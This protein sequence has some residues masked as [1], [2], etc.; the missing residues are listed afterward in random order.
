MSSRST[1]CPPPRVSHRRIPLA[2]C[3]SMRKGPALARTTSSPLPRWEVPQQSVH[4]GGKTRL[5]AR[6]RPLPLSCVGARCSEAGLEGISPSR[7]PYG[8]CP[9]PSEVSEMDIT[10]G[11]APSGSAGKV[12]SQ[13]NPMLA[14]GDGEA[15]ST[16]MSVECSMRAYMRDFRRWVETRLFSYRKY[17][18]FSCKYYVW[19]INIPVCPSHE[20]GPSDARPTVV[21]PS[22]VASC[23]RRDSSRLHADRTA[24]RH[25]HHRRPD[26]PAPAGGA[27]GARGRPP[28]PVRQQPQAARPGHSQLHGRIWSSSRPRSVASRPG[29]ASRTTG[30]AGWCRSCRMMEQTDLFNAYNFAADRAAY[31]DQLDGDGH[32]DRE[33][34]LPE[35]QRPD[36]PDGSGRL[37]QPGTQQARGAQLWDIAGTGDWTLSPGRSGRT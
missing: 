3:A 21:P 12:V 26:R 4:S 9:E 29:S 28:R 10:P 37:E 24:G 5:S 19:L 32:A 33:L 1:S 13:S 31:S 6:E 23:A 27:G 16:R 30:R 17:R 35:L 22:K 36:A 15:A 11:G 34:Y 14:I 2:M 25:R 7:P 20:Y 8:Q 18:D